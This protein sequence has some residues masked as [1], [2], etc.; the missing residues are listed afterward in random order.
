[1]RPLAEIIAMSVD[2]RN[3]MVLL[4][5]GADGFQAICA[6]Q[7]PMAGAFKRKAVRMVVIGAWGDGWDHLSVSLEKRTPTWEE[8]EH[9][10]RLFTQPE[11]TWMQLH[12]PPS[13]HVNINPNVLHLWRPLEGTIPRPPQYMV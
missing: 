10:R 5:Y 7:P 13:D 9:A 1:M 6:F 8:L 2:K 3:Q 4:D 11:E 12:V